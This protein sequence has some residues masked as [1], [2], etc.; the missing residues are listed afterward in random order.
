[1]IR[2]FHQFWQI[3]L[4]KVAPQELPGQTV[5]VCI[6]AMAA[7]LTSLCGLL[8]AFSFGDALL[9]SA[10][11]MLIT[12]SLIAVTLR[13]R[14]LQ[15]RFNQTFAALCGA[16][17]LIYFLAL[18][19]MPYFFTAQIATADGKLLVIVILLFDLWA[20]LVMA[21]VLRHSLDSS[22]ASGMSL[23]IAVTILTVV[24]I[25]SIAPASKIAGK[26]S[27]T[28]DMTTDSGLGG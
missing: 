25:E 9:R 20:L 27:M 11:A 18:P 19:L 1:M 6:A 17:S 2:L 22:F 14:K 16:T 28:N 5:V 15:H 12:A 13:S 24:A 7:L 4:L 3:A 21:N 26:S 8:F 10:L 23:A